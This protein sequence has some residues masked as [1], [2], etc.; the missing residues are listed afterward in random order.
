MHGQDRAIQVSSAGYCNVVFGNFLNH[1]VGGPKNLFVGLYSFE[2]IG[3]LSCLDL[4]YLVFALLTTYGFW[5]GLLCG[6]RLQL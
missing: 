4:D 3:N 5:A 1:N 6:V 2:I